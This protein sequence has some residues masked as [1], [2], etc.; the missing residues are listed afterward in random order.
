MTPSDLIRLSALAHL[1]QPTHGYALVQDLQAQG[2]QIDST[3]TVYRLLLEM[4]DEGLLESTW[5]TPERGPAC[6][7]YRLTSA[8]KDHLVTERK[9]LH[10]HARMVQALLAKI[11]RSL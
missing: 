10:D 3:G 9:K 7:L 11:P 2:H 8:G 5:T 1:H 4:A 6:R